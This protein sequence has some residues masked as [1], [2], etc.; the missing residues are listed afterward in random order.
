MH[1]S[2]CI[3]KY[4]VP[5]LKE[6]YSLFGEVLASFYLII[7]YCNIFWHATFVMYRLAIENGLLQELGIKDSKHRKKIGLRA[8]D[9]V[10]FGPPFSKHSVNVLFDKLNFI[11]FCT[12]ILSSFT[13]SEFLTWPSHSL[14]WLKLW[15][16]CCDEN[17]TF[18][19]K[20]QSVFM[21]HFLQI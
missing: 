18:F 10:L 6:L 7:N 16:L 17:S 11:A 21:Y 8:M 12:C 3:W 9:I 19:F 15:R 4:K 1:K 5:H 13:K 14:C 20:S 2:E